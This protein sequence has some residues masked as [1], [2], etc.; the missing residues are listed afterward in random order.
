VN[1]V[2]PDGKKIVP[3]LLYLNKHGKPVG[4][5]Y[6]SNLMFQRAMTIFGQT[7]YGKQIISSFTPLNYSHYGVQGNGKYANYEM[8]I[9]VGGYWS[10]TD[11]CTAVLNKEGSFII[12]N[13]NGQIKFVFFINTTGKSLGAVVE[14]IVHEFALHGS[15]IP[16]LINLYENVNVS[17]GDGFGAAQRY[18]NK[19]K[20]GKKDHED[21]DNNNLNSKAAR[22]YLQVKEEI[23]L[24]NPEF[25][26]AFE[27]KATNS[28]K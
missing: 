6:Y 3:W 5:E 21:L 1:A 13:E 4:L 22:T 26:K 9:K 24:N 14:T 19:D 8:E 18:F 20:G 16:D 28:N 10:T 23:L 17:G 27:I 15:E 2:D 12:E 7:T 25:R 11:K